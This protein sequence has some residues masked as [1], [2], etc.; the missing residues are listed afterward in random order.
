MNETTET[1]MSNGMT[2][3]GLNG[4][5]NT[6]KRVA[7]KAHEAVDKLEQT[8]NSSTDKVIGWQDEYGGQAREQIKNNPLTAVGIAFAAGILFS[9]IIL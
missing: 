6:V 8:L 5:G 9:K 1:S 4:N 3:T 7:Q 2:S